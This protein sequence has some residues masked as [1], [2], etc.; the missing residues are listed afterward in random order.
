M[1][2]DA[3]TL[4]S[5]TS[6]QADVCVIG[7]GAAGITLALELHGSGLDVLLIESG[8]REQDPAY[9]DLN[10]GEN[11]GR[12]STT[13][14]SPVR[15]DQTRLRYLG[16]T[17]NHW[18]GFC[19]PFSPVDFEVRDHLAVSGW[20]FG[21][22]ELTPYLERAAE[23]VRIGGPDFSL[24][25]WVPR[26]GLPSWE[27]GSDRVETTVYQVTFPTKFGELYG[28]DLESATDVEVLTH[29]SVVN[30]AST[31]GRRVERVDIRT[32]DGVQIEATAT[33]YVLATGGIEN[34]RVLLAS[35]D[36]D[37]GGLGNGNDMVGRYFAEHLQIY[38]GFALLD[39]HPALPGFTGTDHT[40][41]TG[42][43]AGTNHGAKFALGLTDSHVRDEATTGLEI[44]L[45]IGTY[46]DGVPVYRDGT[47]IQAID[48]LLR[49]EG[50]EFGATAY[51]Q[52]LAEQALDPE[53]RVMLDT[54]RD[55][56][57]MR[58]VMLDWRYS[59]ADRRRALDGFRVAAEAIGAAGLGRVQLVPGGVHPDALDNLV[60]DELV[61]AY[62]ASAAAIDEENFPIGMGFHHM[63]TTRMA[64]DPA[65]GVVDPDC[66]MHEVENLW[67]GGSSVFATG[68]V[69]TPTY[70]LVALA[71]RLADHLKA[72]LL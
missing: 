3:R 65:E 58:R 1:L 69:A 18:A 24:D 31:D 61:S 56:L 4:P 32:L 57:G 49:A 50:R 54:T 25:T 55:A 22:E 36:A 40:I 46:P 26:M 52:G 16:G 35:T 34:A 62:S 14:D 38:A 21:P 37:P 71:V 60:R 23:W 6:R 42:R 72:E 5:G 27:L 44:Q 53:S 28:P 12:P 9:Q 15:L 43:H 30:L 41:E 19:R 45:S 2:T 47:P 8:G 7:G 20:P 48:A 63:C 67:I 59:Q 11:I 33:A 10:A 13:L 51:V 17:T 66:R 39:D 64:A 70:T 29:A 68:G